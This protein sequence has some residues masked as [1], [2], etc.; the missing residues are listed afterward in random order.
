MGRT[1]L[2]G[3]DAHL[4]EFGE[5]RKERKCCGFDEEGSQV[6]REKKRFI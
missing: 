4:L 1:D 2:D 3:F 5:G 6:W